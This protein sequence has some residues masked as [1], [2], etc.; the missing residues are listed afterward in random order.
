MKFALHMLSLPLF[1]LAVLTLKAPPGYETLRTATRTEWLEFLDKKPGPG[2]TYHVRIDNG[3]RTLDDVLAE[4]GLNR[5]NLLFS[6]GNSSTKIP[7]TDL[8]EHCVGKLI[9]MAGVTLSLDL[10]VYLPC[11]PRVGKVFVGNGGEGTY[12][13]F[14]VAWIT[15]CAS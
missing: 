10:G 6:C 9:T 7:G 8:S 1:A 5:S 12:D 4:L 11:T 13:I 15:L 2:R 3:P 14:A